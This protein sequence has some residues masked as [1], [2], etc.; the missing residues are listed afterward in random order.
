MGEKN[1]ESGSTAI[2]QTDR[3]TE[4]HNRRPLPPHTAE[5]NSAARWIISALRRIWRR[6]KEAGRTSG[7]EGGGEWRGSAGLGSPDNRSGRPKFQPDWGGERREDEENKSDFPKETGR[8]VRTQTPG[9]V[10]SFIPRVD[11]DAASRP[12]RELKP[13]SAAVIWPTMSL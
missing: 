5:E 7:M 9:D 2:R 13:D 1:C 12:I 8:G 6:L 3:Q 11:G 4:W 10:A